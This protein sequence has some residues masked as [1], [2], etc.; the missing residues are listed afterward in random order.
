MSPE[1]RKI[2]MREY[3]EANRE[4]I[5]KSNRKASALYREKNPQYDA[6]RNDKSSEYNASYRENNRG[7][8]REASRIWALSNP[9]KGAEKRLKRYNKHT[10]AIPAWCET[11]AIAIL[12][13]I[14]DK[15]AGEHHVDHVIPLQ[16]DLVCGLHCY[17]NLEVIPAFDNLSKKNR[18]D[19]DLE[20]AKQLEI[21][22]LMSR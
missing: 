16:H 4:N 18:F 5:R 21:S 1:E 3:R 22:K 11:A 19:Q 13:R 9:E 6:T 17:A 20:S 10:Q 7:K 12:Y 15:R 8:I 14:R 2:Y